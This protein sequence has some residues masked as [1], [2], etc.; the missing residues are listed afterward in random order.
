MNIIRLINKLTAAKFAALQQRG[1][2]RLRIREKRKR[3]W[4]ARERGLIA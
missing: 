4:S 1:L 3:A 2:F